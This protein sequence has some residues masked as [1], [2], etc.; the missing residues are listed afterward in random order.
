MCKE[1]IN[2]KAGAKQRKIKRE[3]YHLCNYGIPFSFL[4]NFEQSYTWIYQVFLQL[5]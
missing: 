4:L 2:I 3:C 5:Q 1:S